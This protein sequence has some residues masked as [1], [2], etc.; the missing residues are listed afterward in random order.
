MRFADRAEA[1]GLTVRPHGVYEYTDCLSAVRYM[2]VQT[3]SENMDIPVLAIFTKGPTDDDYSYEGIVSDLYQ[4]EGNECINRSV[5]DSI[6]GLGA[7]LLSEFTFLDDKLTKM[8]KELV[9]SNK[10][11]IPQVGDLYP[12]VTVLNTYNGHGAKDIKF[13]LTMMEGNQRVVGFGFNTNV[14]SLRQVHVRHARTHATSIGTYLQAFNENISDIVRSN[15]QN[16]VTDDDIMKT[17]DLIEKIG[18]RKRE[19]IEAT[20][21]ELKKESGFISN[22]NVFLAI[23]KY[24]SEEK[25]INVKSLMEDVAERVLVLPQRMLDLVGK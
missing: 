4:F 19:K 6:S 17:L 10:T 2:E 7:P 20:L 25:N 22:W 23:T 5:R 13:G 1:M 15:M 24:S 12:Q 14:V 9:V 18:K 3:K 11:N 8:R 16:R 21:T